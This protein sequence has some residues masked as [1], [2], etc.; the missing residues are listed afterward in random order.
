MAAHIRIMMN[1]PVSNLQY[2]YTSLAA[3]TA[4]TLEQSILACTNPKAKSS[5]QDYKAFLKSPLNHGPIIQWSADAT[6]HAHIQEVKVPAQLSNNQNYYDQIAHYLNH[7]DKDNPSE[8]DD[9]SEEEHD[10][11]I[12]PDNHSLCDHMMLPCVPLNY[13]VIANALIQ[14]WYKLHIQQFFYHKEQNIDALQ[15]LRALPPSGDNPHGLYDMV[16]LSPGP[17]S[18]WPWLIFCPLDTD[19]FAA[20]IQ[21]FNV[22]AQPGNSV[23]KYLPSSPLL[24]VPH[25]LTI[26][27]ACN[28]NHATWQ[29][30]SIESV[31]EHL[32]ENRLWNGSRWQTYPSGSDK[33]SEEDLILCEDSTIEKCNVQQECQF[34]LRTNVYVIREVKIKNSSDNIKASFIELTGKVIFQL[35]NQDSQY[36]MPGLQILGNHIV[37]TLFDWGGSISTHP[38]NIHKHPRAFLHI[39]MGITFGD[40]V[41]LGFDS[42]ISPIKGGRKKIQIIKNGQEY[43]IAVSELL[44]ISGLLHGQGM[45]V[46]SSVIT[47][48]DF[49]GLAEG[50]KVVVKD[51]FVDPLQQYTQGKILKILEESEIEGGL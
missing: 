9:E 16:I 23:D 31:L 34:D 27:T 15:T 49:P 5:M 33:Y 22:I 1:N 26:T 19:Y 3:Y 2:C 6:K 20:Y 21:C 40:G 51:S 44:F 7:S 18:D 46:W 28:S 24:V 41:V 37:L 14:I 30:T 29:S 17:D 42:T 10:V 8:D 4:D 36:A 13:F 47:L 25:P 45:T 43:F 38:L 39:L 35:K 11:K 32:E 12:D 50:Q 48:D